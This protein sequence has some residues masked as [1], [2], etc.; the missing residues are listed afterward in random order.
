MPPKTRMTADEVKADLE[1]KGVTVDNS[2]RESKRQHRK[3]EDE[4]SQRFAGVVGNLIRKNQ[5]DR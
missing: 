4:V 1:K 3:R 2:T 5:G